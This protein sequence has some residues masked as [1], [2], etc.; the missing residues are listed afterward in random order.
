MDTVGKVQKG[1]SYDDD[2]HQ[3]FVGT[4]ETV[5]IVFNFSTLMIIMFTTN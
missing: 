4:D 3:G 5:A 1:V 2:L